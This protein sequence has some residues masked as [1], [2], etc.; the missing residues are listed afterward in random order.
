MNE[1]QKSLILG[2]LL[3]DG[4]LVRLKKHP[5]WNWGFAKNQSKNDINGFDKKSF[6]EYHKLTLKSFI[7]G[8]IYNYHN[9][10]ILIGENKKITSETFGYVY[11]TRTHPLFTEIGKKWY[12]INENNTRTKIVPK[13]L[14]LDPLSMCIWYMDDGCKEKDKNRCRI[15]TNG[16]NHEEVD[17]LV[18]LINSTFKLNSF[19]I[20]NKKN[21]PMI[22]IGGYKNYKK[23]RDLILPC[24]SWNCFHHKIETPKIVVYLSGQN[25]PRSKITDNDVQEIK[26]LYSEGMSQTKIAPLFGIKRNTISTILTGDSWQST[27]T[28]KEII[29]QGNKGQRNPNSKLKKEDVVE[30]LSLKGKMTYEKI[31]NKYGV[32]KGAISHIMN[33]HSWI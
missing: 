6:L 19:K 17:F 30:I 11:R 4:C 20:H 18:K 29:S 12:V 33:G 8:N 10:P 16:F 21:E 27:N 3:G 23:F 5:T 1:I 2:S 24:V 13:S 25:H 7:V 9:R 28:S 22:E 31:G 14:K 26:R 32:T 15:A